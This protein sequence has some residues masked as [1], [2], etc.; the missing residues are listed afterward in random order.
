M[1]A[2]MLG[3]LDR[4]LPCSIESGSQQRRIVTVGAR[5]DHR[6][7]YAVGV[8]HGGA[9]DASLSPVHRAFARLLAPARSLRDTAIDA[10]IGH[11]QADDPIA[12]EAKAIRSRASITPA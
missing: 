10:K 11:L 2:G 8:H 12:L 4:S 1:D 5:R 9:F 6:E 3:Q 7:G